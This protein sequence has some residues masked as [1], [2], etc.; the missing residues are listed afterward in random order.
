MTRLEDLKF[1]D[2]RA[3]IGFGKNRLPHWEQEGAVYFVIF[4]LADSVPQQLLLRWS[5]EN[6][7][8]LRQ[9]PPPWTGAV[10]RK[11]HV[12]FSAAIERWLD[13]GHGACVLRQPES[14]EV[15]AGALRYFE[16][17][18]CEQLAW[19]VM[20]NHVHALFG[21]KAGYE[22]GALVRSWK[23]FSARR[24]NPLKGK[25]GALWQKDYFDRLVRDAAHF[26]RCVRYIRR[27]AEKAGLRAGEFLLWES[28]VARGIG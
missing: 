10:E 4:R 23:L 2:P 22:L 11:Y 1:F 26:A 14:A 18:R 17:Q 3:E 19:V 24:I 16:G 8:W 13:A 27:N 9:H 25:T 5:E 15:V 20:P 12:R 6:E 28:E 21:L 7:V